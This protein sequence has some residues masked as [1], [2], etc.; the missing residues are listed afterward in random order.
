MGPNIPCDP[1]PCPKQA[2]EFTTLG[3]GLAAVAV[4]AVGLWLMKKK[5]K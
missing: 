5:K 3:I 1:N 2:P 4:G